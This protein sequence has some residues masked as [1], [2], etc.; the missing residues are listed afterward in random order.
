VGRRYRELLLLRE[1][2]LLQA[3]EMVRILL[4]GL[5]KRRGRK[6]EPW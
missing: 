1:W 5:K 4:V 2:W 3:V 6:D